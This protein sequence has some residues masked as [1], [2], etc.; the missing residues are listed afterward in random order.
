MNKIL[1]YGFG[2]PGRQ[3]DGLG[4]AF[5]ER[6][7][8]WVQNEGIQNVEFDSNYQLNIE[9]AATIS[10]KDLVVFVDASVEDIEDIILTPVD[11]SAKVAFSSHSAS[12]G[13]I[14]KLCHDLFNTQPACYLLHIKGYEWEFMGGLTDKAKQNLEKSLELL[15]EKIRNPEELI[16]SFVPTELC[17]N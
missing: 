9:D 7:E 2:N 14:V 4:N 1:I 6:L 12:P 11:E 10:D 17:E 15:K 8:E 13:Y 3:D 16:S 5:V